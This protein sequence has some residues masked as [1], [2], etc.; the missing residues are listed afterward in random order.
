MKIVLGRKSN[1]FSPGN[2]HRLKD[3]PAHF[4]Y[5]AEF[6]LR[7]PLKIRAG[8]GAE[9]LKLVRDVANGDCKAPNDIFCL[10]G[11][12]HV[13]EYVYFSDLALTE[14]ASPNDPHAKIFGLICQQG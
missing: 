9:K 12:I 14:L 10:P 5:L 11:K 7:L 8:F 6:N 3:A 13:Q 1:W 2:Y 4:R